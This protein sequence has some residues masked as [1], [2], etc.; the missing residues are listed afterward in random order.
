MI[1]GICGLI[2][3]GKRHYPD[4]LVTNYN[5]KKLIICGQTKDSVATMFDWDRELTVKQTNR[6]G[7]KEDDYWTK[8]L[9]YSVTP[10]IGITKKSRQNVCV[11]DFMTE[12]GL[13]YKEKILDNPRC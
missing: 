9:G 7:V 4:Y 11:M 13:V 12:Y 10:K 2:G 3:S 6:A 5:F 8:E 1:I